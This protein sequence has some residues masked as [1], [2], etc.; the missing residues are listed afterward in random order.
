MPNPFFKGQLNT[1]RT[2]VERPRPVMPVPEQYAGDN[3]PYRGIEAHGVEANARPA[4]DPDTS[5]IDIENARPVPYEPFEKE[6]TPV[7]VR[8]IRGEGDTGREYRQFWTDRRSVTDGVSPL[9]GRDDN[10]V[11]AT[12]TNTDAAKTVYIASNFADLAQRGY[13]LSPGKDRTIAGEM[14]VFV[15][16]ADGTAVIIGMYV[17]TTVKEP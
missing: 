13:P 17:E 4:I 16:S 2:R 3:N 5:A 9:L 6:E 1:S 11:T 15:S 14:P 12:I 7:P 8:I 10:R